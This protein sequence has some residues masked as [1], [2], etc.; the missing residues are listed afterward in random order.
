MKKLFNWLSIVMVLFVNS[1]L[2]CIICEDI[3]LYQIIY[4]RK[5]T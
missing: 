3:K 5:K 1:F 4:S 2:P